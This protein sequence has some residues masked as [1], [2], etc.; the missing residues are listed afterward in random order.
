MAAADAAPN[1]PRV[2]A[3][4]VVPCNRNMSDEI[5]GVC[6][7][8]S[9]HCSSDLCDA[10]QHVDYR[11]LR[12]ELRRQ[13]CSKDRT[14]V[15]N[16]FDG[17][18][19]CGQALSAHPRAAQAPRS[20]LVDDALRQIVEVRS[21]EFSRGDDSLSAEKMGL[22]QAEFE[23]HPS[24]L[25]DRKWAEMLQCIRGRSKEKRLLDHWKVGALQSALSRGDREGK[26]KPVGDVA[27]REI[28]S[29]CIFP[30][31]RV[32]EFAGLL[33]AITAIAAHNAS[34][35]N[36]VTVPRSSMEEEAVGVTLA[37]EALNE[38]AVQR[39]LKEGRECFLREAGV[40][41]ER[42]RGD[43]VKYIRLDPTKDQRKAYAWPDRYTKIL[44]LSYQAF[45]Q[46]RPPTWVPAAL[47]QY[48]LCQWSFP[49]REA[50][51]PTDL[52]GIFVQLGVLSLV[53]QC[54]HWDV[55][56][57]SLAAAKAHIATA[58][59]AFQTRFVL[60]AAN[61]QENKRFAHPA[62]GAVA[63]SG[64]PRKPVLPRS[65]NPVG[66]HSAQ[67]SSPRQ[68]IPGTSALAA[69]IPDALAANI[70]PSTRVYNR[71]Q[72]PMCASVP[73]RGF[74]TKPFCLAHD[75]NPVFNSGSSPRGARGGSHGRGRR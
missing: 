53:H 23:A 5:D 65:G 1:I 8:C 61:L 18:C 48:L 4:S 71:C 7:F 3:Y 41:R 51:L 11:E 67:P 26:E 33:S 60:S 52:T 66:T 27:A 54:E 24:K 32:R 62:D 40:I 36:V 64:S 20:T 74:S 46:N 21:Q 63:A 47:P 29:R 16:E 31:G 70:H 12:A 2:C 19:P 73:P 38:V 17:V 56:G 45:L 13:N 15:A 14:I 59:R 37:E 50:A 28:A 68:P 69:S 57:E 34:G 22:T 35:A 49:L 55:L 39:L 6:T 10:K 30:G 44:F 25:S 58:Y 43:I 9:R 42:H 75:P 72:S